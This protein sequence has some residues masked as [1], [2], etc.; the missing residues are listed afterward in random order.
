MRPLY[1]GENVRFF[2]VDLSNINDWICFA[3]HILCVVYENI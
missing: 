2:Y 1:N 3:I